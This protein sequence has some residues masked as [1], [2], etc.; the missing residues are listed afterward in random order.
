MQRPLPP[1]P[2]H[3]LFRIHH[4]LHRS[5]NYLEMDVEADVEFG[6]G[7]PEWLSEAMQCRPRDSWRSPYDSWR[8]VR[9]S[10]GTAH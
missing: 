7:T 5:R 10:W 9:E 3:V 1:A 6:D 8:P 4:E 2:S